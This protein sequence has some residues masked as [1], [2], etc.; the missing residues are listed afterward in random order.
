ME[1]ESSGKENSQRQTSFEII[2]IGAVKVK[3]QK[4]ITDSFHRLIKPQVYNW[5]HDS[6]H[7]VIHVDYKDLMSG[8]PFEQAA[9]EFLDWCGEDW[10]FLPGEIRM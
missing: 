2:E 5:I 3:Q 9:R 6:I 4:E 1:S 8:V 10:Y 7:E